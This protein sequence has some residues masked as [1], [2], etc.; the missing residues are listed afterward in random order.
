M[1]HHPLYTSSR[2]SSRLNLARVVLSRARWSRISGDCSGRPFSHSVVGAWGGS[3]VVERAN[4]TPCWAPCGVGPFP[5]LSQSLNRSTRARIRSEVDCRY[6]S[7][8]LRI[9]SRTT[10][11]QPS[12]PVR[13]TPPA[14]SATRQ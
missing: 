4:S 10:G 1:S 11:I 3:I 6:S 9:R 14:F 2:Q 13:K 12:P 8:S 7:P 5:R